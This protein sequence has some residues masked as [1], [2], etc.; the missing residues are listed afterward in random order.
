[1]LKTALGP[2]LTPNILVD[3]MNA[4][5]NILVALSSE[6]TIS[7]SI[8]ALLAELDIAVPSERTGLVVDHF[9][10]DAASASEKHDVLLLAPPAPLRPGVQ[11]YFTPAEP[12]SELIAFPRGVGHTLGQGPLLN[13]ILRAPSTAYSYDPKEQADGVDPQDLFA[14]GA[15]LGLVSTMQSRNSARFA[16]V[17]SAEMLTDKWFDAKVKKIGGK[18]VAT[19]NRE[20]AKRV[21]GWTFQEIGVLRVNSIEHRL[22]EAGATETNP[23][24]YRIKNDVVRICLSFRLRFLEYPC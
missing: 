12:I 6:T 9:N 4:H 22:N 11:T 16:I 23:K 2:N 13:P 5:G 3:F 7:S 10:Y 24:G 18:E 8:T 21:S 1:L 19:W 15:Q 17:G 20:F 14:V